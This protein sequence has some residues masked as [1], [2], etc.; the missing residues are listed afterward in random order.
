MTT[1]TP[2]QAFDLISSEL[3]TI[4]SDLHNTTHM[5]TNIQLRS[6]HLPC[7]IKIPLKEVWRELQRASRFEDHTVAMTYAF[8]LWELLESVT[9][10]ERNYYIKKLEITKYFACL[11]QYT[12][13]ML[14]ASSS[15]ITSDSTPPPYNYGM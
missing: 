6:Y 14:E 5:G 3:R 11:P 13:N 9:K 15:T 4:M 7:E 8:F 12:T 2:T 10:S 1:V